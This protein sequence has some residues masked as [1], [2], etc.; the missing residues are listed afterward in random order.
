MDKF[1]MIFATIP[2]ATGALIAA[3]GLAV[4]LVAMRLARRQRLRSVALESSLDALRNEAKLAADLS[5]RAGRHVER[6]E[7][8]CASLAAR[9][10]RIERRAD[11]R[12]FDR[13]IDSARL[14]AD[15]GQL[16]EQFG[17]SRGEADLVTRLHCRKK[18]A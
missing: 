3:P 11:A 15:S 12:S 9:V 13:A 1:M 7:R 16:S 5:L 14:G 2:V 4:A 6:M 10:E 18:I 8:D 17:L